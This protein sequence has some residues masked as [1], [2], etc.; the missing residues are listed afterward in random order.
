ML[1]GG[2]SGLRI[3]VALLF[4]L[5]LFTLL[6]STFRTSLSSKV[7]NNEALDDRNLKLYLTDLE[8]SRVF[9]HGFDEIDIAKARGP[10]GKAPRHDYEHGYMRARIHDGVVRLLPKRFSSLI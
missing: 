6:P 5:L 2:R 9:P 1:P 7:R 3:V 4:F 8:C 10:I